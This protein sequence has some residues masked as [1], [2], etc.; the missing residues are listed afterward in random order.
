MSVILRASVLEEGKL[1]MNRFNS[2]YWS[3]PICELSHPFLSDLP[4]KLP[5]LVDPMGPP[6]SRQI[7]VER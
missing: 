2:E 1:V 6:E 4:Q 3:F 7:G 5:P